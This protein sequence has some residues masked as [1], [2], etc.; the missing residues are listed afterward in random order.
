MS[1][2]VYPAILSSAAQL[3]GASDSD[4]RRQLFELELEHGIAAIGRISLALPS[5]R[6]PLRTFFRPR[7]IA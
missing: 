4:G 3:A 7:T 5:R 2:T 6:C 1:S